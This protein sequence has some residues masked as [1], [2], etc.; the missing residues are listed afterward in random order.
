MFDLISNAHAEGGAVPEAAMGN[1]VF[2][3]LLFAIFYFL[4]IRPQ[5][6]QAKA[7]KELVANLA[8]G[9]SV[10]TSAGLI[11]KIHR[12]EEDLVVMDV[13]EVE[14]SPK[15]F[16]QVRLRVRRVNIAEVT[17]KA[18]VASE[19]SVSLQK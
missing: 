14:V 13:G 18:G 3:V 1:I 16:R 2:M 7:H 12:V 8:R 17:A 4:L 15:T 6:K 11:G 9:D 5:Q 19:D 10:I